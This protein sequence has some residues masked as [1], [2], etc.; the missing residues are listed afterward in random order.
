MFVLSILLVF[1]QARS[2][3][4]IKLKNHATVDIPSF[5]PEIVAISADQSVLCAVDGFWKTLEIARVSWPDAKQSLKLDFVDLD[6]EWEGPQGLSFY[7]SPTSVAAH[8]ALPI[9]F[10]TTIGATPE[11]RGEIVAID[12][13]KETL[14]KRLWTQAVGRHPDSIAA[15]PDGKWLVIANEGE[16]DDRASVAPGSVTVIR[17][18]KNDLLKHKTYEGALPS[19]ELDVYQDLAPDA[20][21]VEPEF[22]VMDPQ[23]RFAIVTCQ[24]N[25]S[26]VIISLSGEEPK[27]SN[28]KFA[29]SL[30][31]EPDGAA[32]LDEFKDT[33]RGDG[34][35]VAFAE[36][37]KF[38]R[39][40]RWLGQ[41]LSLHWVG[42][43]AECKKT[44]T[45]A[46]VNI[47]K[48]LGRENQITSP[49]S[50]LLKR[51]DGGVYCFV[52][53]ERG[54]CVLMFDVT[55]PRE[56]VLMDNVRVGKRP[57]G[58]CW[59]KRGERLFIVTGD[60]GNEGPGEISFVEVVKGGKAER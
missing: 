1:A 42:P 50:V 20:G 60:E 6:E 56:P 9:A 52:G 34:V 41:N 48:L 15:S 2:A 58:M 57:E 32:I 36:E 16:G 29:L 46:R 22:V 23:S 24:E 43:D 54:N 53:V 12:L 49:E 28:A 3:P 25:N 4:G 37:G 7:T 51:I 35:L 26:A 27:V 40:G 5:A 21:E 44:E 33:V 31:A 11:R 8:P 30:G 55:N 38:D 45:L 17:I 14:G 47:A 39:F 13:R 59:V 10:V 19:W 18:D